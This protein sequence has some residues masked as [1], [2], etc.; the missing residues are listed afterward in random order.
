MYWNKWAHQC[1]LQLEVQCSTPVSA[2]GA[3]WQI[4]H[5]DGVRLGGGTADTGTGCDWE[6][7]W[8]NTWYRGGARRN[9]PLPTNER[10]RSAPQ[11]AAI[12]SI[13]AGKLFRRSLVPPRG[14]GAE[15][16]VSCFHYLWRPRVANGWSCGCV[17]LVPEAAGR[18]RGGTQKG[19]MYFAD[20]L[21][22]K[23]ANL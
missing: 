9:I 5:C 3:S 16:H 18:M 21:L 17:Y 15:L 13:R 20:A 1:T 8:Q 22:S 7:G 14:Q 10:R 11:W 4:L 19:S 6:K 12:R 23:S 2:V